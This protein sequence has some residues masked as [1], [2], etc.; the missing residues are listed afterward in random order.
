METE[1]L[2]KKFYSSATFLFTLLGVVGVIW[3]ISLMKYAFI[4]LGASVLLAYL[5][6]PLVN[7]FVSPIRLKLY[8]AWFKITPQTR[9][10][11]ILDTKKGLPR[12]WGIVA[13]YVLLGLIF[14]VILSYVIPSIAFEFKK[15]IHN[16]PGL[17]EAGHQKFSFVSNWI[18][19]RVPPFLQ[20]SYRQIL[21]K[22]ER[23]A[24]NFSFTIIHSTFPVAQKV[25]SGLT[26]LLLL[27]LITFYI[28]MDTDRYKTGFLAL[29]PKAKKAE[30]T[31]I[32]TRIDQALGRFIRGQIVVCAIIGASV[33]VILLIFG[34]EY[35]Y[36]IG[37]FAGIIDF[38]PYVGVIC[39][40]IPAVLLALLKSPF[41]AFLLLAVLLFVHWAEGH[42]IVPSVMGQAVKL[43]SLVILI[44]LIIGFE[45]MGI[46]GA[47]FAVPVASI[48]RVL[49]EYYEEKLQREA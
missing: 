38:I 37:A 31:E 34:I 27:P 16:L 28:L 1:L 49:L 45:L 40:L 3:I 47:L 46:T 18:S 7:F 48:T 32:M 14:F 17:A 10:I 5:L 13:V 4:L 33:T 9:A 43:P 21:A 2:R 15:L 25:L 8:L 20:E 22:L 23:E 6:M 41:T 29:I 11:T 24:Q 35:P 19:V 26:G 42:I 44:S 36:L 39:G 12:L 30:V